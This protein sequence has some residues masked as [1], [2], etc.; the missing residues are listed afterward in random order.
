MPRPDAGR[1]RDAHPDQLPKHIERERLL[2]V[3]DAL[4]ELLHVVRY[5][6]A[7]GGLIAV[8]CLGHEQ[9]LVRNAEKANDL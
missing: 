8:G 6:C 5:E 3:V 9:E 7:D 4:A 1:S 2:E